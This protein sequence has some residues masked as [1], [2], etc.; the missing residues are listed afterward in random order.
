MTLSSIAPFRKCKNKISGFSVTFLRLRIVAGL[1]NVD[2]VAKAHQ[3][4]GS[5]VVSVGEIPA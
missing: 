4:N 3:I 2:N 1:L 5:S